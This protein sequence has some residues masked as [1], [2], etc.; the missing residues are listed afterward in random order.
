MSNIFCQVIFPEAT[1]KIEEVFKA[2]IFQSEFWLRTQWPGQDF[3]A[4]IVVTASRDHGGF[5]YLSQKVGYQGNQI[6]PKP[7]PGPPPS[8][9][10]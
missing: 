2:T 5:P 10:Y 4:P 3:I 7:P 9:G 1:G 8:C 6:R